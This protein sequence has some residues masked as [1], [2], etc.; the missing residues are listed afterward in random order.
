MENITLQAKKREIFGKKNKT[1]REKGFIPAVIYGKEKESIPLEINLKEFEEV[2]KKTGETDI[3]SLEIEGEKETRKVLV[4]EVKRHFLTNKPIHV[5]F[6]EVEMDKPITT[7]VPIT[8][9][10][11][12]PAVKAGGILVQSMDEIEIEALPKDI[13]HEIVVDVSGLTEIGQTIYVKDLKLKE[14][15]K[16]LVDSHNPICTISAPLSEEELEKELGRVKTAEEVEVTGA[17][18][19]K[20][21]EE[22]KEKTEESK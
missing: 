20:P 1:L 6:Y 2:F 10:G 5:D 12:S 21:L 9:V 7:S 14:G 8:L 15:I 11:E 4:Q 3:F 13:P 16:I 22:A 19:E 17:K 18:E